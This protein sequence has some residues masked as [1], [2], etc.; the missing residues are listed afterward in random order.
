MW[1]AF[2][3]IPLI[4]GIAWFIFSW[5][6]WGARGQLLALSGLMVGLGASSGLL[7]QAMRAVVPQRRPLG[8]SVSTYT[9]LSVGM[10]IAMAVVLA[11]VAFVVPFR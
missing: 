1:S 10:A 7:L 4:A 3:Y 8:L 11:V 9:Y 6:H 5:H 2:S